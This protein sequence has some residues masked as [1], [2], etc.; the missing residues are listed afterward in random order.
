MTFQPTEQ[1]T[2]QPTFHPTE[3][4]T[5]HPTEQPTF[6]LSP[7][8]SQ[9]QNSKIPNP[10]SL[11]PDPGP[12]QMPTAQS[13]RVSAIDVLPADFSSASSSNPVFF[14]IAN[15]VPEYT[16]IQ[17]NITKSS[18]DDNALLL[19]RESR[20]ELIGNYDSCPLQQGTLV[21][22]N[23]GLSKI[24]SINMTMD[25]VICSAGGDVVG[26]A[27]A[28]FEKATSPVPTLSPTRFPRTQILPDNPGGNYQDQNDDST[29]LLTILLTTAIVWQ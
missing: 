19:N 21:D 5:F 16:V 28:I 22:F 29:K 25:I 27:E 11:S 26:I 17:V 6:H 20:R 2:E 24:I 18:I 12:S 4:P 9:A 8:P 14:T 10:T 7:P 13:T 23:G 1:P 15:K 3:Q